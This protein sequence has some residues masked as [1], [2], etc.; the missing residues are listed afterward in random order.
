MYL[1][2]ILA[3]FVL[4][5]LYIV[6]DVL[7][8]LLPPQLD[9]AGQGVQLLFSKA[10]DLGQACIWMEEHGLCC[11][12]P[13][14]ARPDDSVSG[15]AGGCAQVIMYALDVNVVTPVRASVL[16]AAVICCCCVSVPGS[17]E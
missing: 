17:R 5:A 2:F 14:T 3:Q 12:A 6:L 10:W 16:M 11:F 8:E 15:C 9:A 7:L 1:L 13:S 4:S